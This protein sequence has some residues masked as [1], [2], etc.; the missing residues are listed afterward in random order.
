MP[1]ISFIIPCGRI[2]FYNAGRYTVDSILDNHI[3]CEIV[4]SSKEYIDYRNCKFYQESELNVGAVEPINQM[5]NIASGEFICLLND[6]FHLKDNI[7]PAIIHI[8]KHGYMGLTLMPLDW[9]RTGYG[10]IPYNSKQQLT[11]SNMPF[12]IVRKEF[13]L[14]NQTLLYPAFNHHYADC[15]LALVL[16][17]IYHQD[18]IVFDN[19]HLYIYDNSNN[20]SLDYCIKYNTKDFEIYQSFL[21]EINKTYP[22]E[23]EL[24]WSNHTIFPIKK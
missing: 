10:Y 20:K 8:I 7:T 23:K 19:Q 9:K 14:K 18:E 1:L 4:L 21:G 22:I 13:I 12:P 16:K 3:D 6:D 17:L 15:A 24:I 2:P 11:I 5:A